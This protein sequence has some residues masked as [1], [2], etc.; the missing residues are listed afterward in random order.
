MATLST[1]TTELQEAAEQASKGVRD[2]ESMRQASQSL[3][4]ARESTLQK[5]G[6]VEVAVELVREAR[7]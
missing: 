2:V 3:D 1:P 6:T 7:E 4:R 5:I